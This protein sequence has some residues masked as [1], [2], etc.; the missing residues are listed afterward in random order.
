MRGLAIGGGVVRLRLPGAARV[1][2]ERGER[3]RAE[4][5]L[6]VV[7]VRGA[8]R[9][10][11]GGYACVWGRAMATRWWCQPRHASASVG[12]VARPEV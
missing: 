6:G 8:G 1:L 4:L 11:D 5:E 2:R 7:R 12:A 3:G 10:F 9:V